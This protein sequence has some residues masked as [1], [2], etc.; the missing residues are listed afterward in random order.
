MVTYFPFFPSIS[1]IIFSIFQHY[2]SF[3]FYSFNFSSLCF[4]SFILL[5]LFNV[6]SVSFFSFILVPNSFSLSPNLIR[7]TTGSPLLEE[8][9]SRLLERY[10]HRERS[11]RSY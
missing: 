3:L 10:L 1:S 11:S 4:Y 2:V 5:D 9:P 8:V 6:S 7:C